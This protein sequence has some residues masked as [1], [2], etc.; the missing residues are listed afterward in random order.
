MLF[1]VLILFV[2]H[3]CH[4]QFQSFPFDYF[5]KTYTVE[6]F[7]KLDVCYSKI[8]LSDAKRII[9]YSS[10]RNDSDEC[11]HF[12]KFACGQFYEFKPL[13]ERYRTVGFENDLDVQYNYYM[14]LMLKKKIDKNEPKIFK[15]LKKYYQNCVSSGE[16]NICSVFKVEKKPDFNFIFKDYVRKDGKEE[17]KSYLEQ[18]GKLPIFEENWNPSDFNVTAAFIN[19]HEHL[20]KFQR[21]FESDDFV[22][23]ELPTPTPWIILP[24]TIQ[25]ALKVDFRVSTV[26]LSEIME[27]VNTNRQFTKYTV[28]YSNN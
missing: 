27:I 19:E 11:N 13:N 22:Y 16:L 12:N 23:M 15:L 4:G 2:L 14:K 21:L 8:C 25:N 6:E 17:F 7:K 18:F 10:I 3:E 28:R 5:G 26:V 1:K 24:I 9:A 20:L